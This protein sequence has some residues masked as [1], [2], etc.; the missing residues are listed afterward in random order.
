MTQPPTPAS[1]H[2]TGEA[3]GRPCE[4]NP[5]TTEQPPEVTGASDG[6]CRD[7]KQGRVDLHCVLPRGHEGWHVATYRDH[8]TITYDGARHEVT[9]TE[10]VTWEPVDHVREAVRRLMS[11]RR[12][13]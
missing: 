6:E 7:I 1:Q 3:A 5:V 11:D 13:R 8:Q 10:E 9:L 2:T 4:E 12:T